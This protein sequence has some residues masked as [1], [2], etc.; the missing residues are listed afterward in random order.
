[1]KI[2]RIFEAINRIKEKKSTEEKN[3]REEKKP[4]PYLGTY[5]IF[6][7]FHALYQ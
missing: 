4:H 6:M 7:G 1:M 2:D 5:V 3:L